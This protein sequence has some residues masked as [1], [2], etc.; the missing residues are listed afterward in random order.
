MG[1]LIPH[2][3]GHFWV[4]ILDVIH[5][6]SSGM[7]PLATSTVATCFTYYTTSEKKTNLRSF[8]CVAVASAAN[9]ANKEEVSAV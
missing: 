4:D 7:R 3:K 6:R 9:E 1:D 5:K 8:S 2:R